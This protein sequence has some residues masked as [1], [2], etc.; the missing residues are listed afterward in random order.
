MKTLNLNFFI[1]LFCVV[2]FI[3]GFG[4]AQQQSSADTTI[5][6]PPLIDGIEGYAKEKK[7]LFVD[8]IIILSRDGERHEFSVELAIDPE[9]QR[10]G[11]MYRKSMASD[12]GM[13]FIFPKSGE[14]SFWMKNTLIPL[15]LLFIRGDGVIHHIHEM[16]KPK[17]LQSIKSNG[18]TLAVLEI[19]GGESKRQGINIGDRV[20]GER[21]AHV[22]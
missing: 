8:D 9:Q 5:K 17:S 6:I 2:V 18:A 7:A 15:D 12:K 3:S 10:Q 14:R 19:S 16:A 22:K 11:L 21:F 4:V 20:L 1:M 13:L